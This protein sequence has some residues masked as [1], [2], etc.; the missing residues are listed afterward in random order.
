[1]ADLYPFQQELLNRVMRRPGIK[2]GEMM[3]MTAGRNV[4]KSYVNNII[5]NRYATMREQY[6]P[7]IRWQQLP[8]LKLQ[9]YA[10][11]IELRGLFI[12]L[13]ENDM[14]PV[15]VWAAECNCGTRM[16]FDVWKFAN[17]KQITMFLIRWA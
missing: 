11:D 5:N 10:D 17:E 15:Q 8:G 4:G 12:G 13:N 16:S 7:T 3:T 9:A 14:N 1:M 2:P 6:K